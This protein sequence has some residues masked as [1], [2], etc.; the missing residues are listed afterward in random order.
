MQDDMSP[1]KRAFLRRLLWMGVLSA[2]EPLRQG[3][4]QVLGSAPRQR[5]ASKSIYRL[6][7]S[8]RINGAEASAD[9][10][11]VGNESVETGPRA[12][13]VFVVGQDA[14]LVRPNSRLELFAER[15]GILTAF[16]VL[17]GALVSAHGTAARRIDT[18]SATIGIRGTSVYTEVSADRTY[19][20]TCYGQTEI[21]VASESREKSAQRTHHH[22][23]PK[24][25][26]LKPHAGRSIFP[27]PMLN[28]SDEEL[29]LIEALVGR[30][31]PFFTPDDA[32][33]PARRR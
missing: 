19:F 20:C 13:A 14:F 6:R 8:V 15:L 31:T 10:I 25:I 30:K 23:A 3:E 33:G 18:P 32:W 21:T 1:Q 4:A 24:H 27:A 17:T 26:L 2:M 16:R 9:T 12:E 7:G 5:P 29:T 28:H 11:I 22:D